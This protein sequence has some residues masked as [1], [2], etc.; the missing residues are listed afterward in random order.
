GPQMPVGE[1]SELL[2][3]GLL[4]RL[5]ATSF[6]GK[7]TQRG[8]NPESTL[9]VHFCDSHPNVLRCIQ[10]VSVDVGE[11]AEMRAR[12]WWQFNQVWDSTGELRELQDSYF[13]STRGKQL[14]VTSL[15]QGES[16]IFIQEF[17]A[18]PDGI[19]TVKITANGRYGGQLSTREIRS[20]PVYRIGRD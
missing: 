17:K 16:R 18:L 6:A 2:S 20:V 8:Y 19:E 9:T 14:A 12:E 3:T 5:P 11:A 10:T 7:I 1:T 15:G 13:L 4:S